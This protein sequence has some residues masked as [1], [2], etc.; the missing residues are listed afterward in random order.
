[1]KRISSCF[2]LSFLILLIASQF[3]CA[4]TMLSM[5]KVEK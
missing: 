3:S 5:D 1:M 4:E 2:V